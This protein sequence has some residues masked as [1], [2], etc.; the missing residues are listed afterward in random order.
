MKELELPWTKIKEVTTDGAASMIGKKIG[1]MG[2][3]RREIYKQNPEFYMNF[4][5]SATKSHVVDKH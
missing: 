4:T 3:I 5:A 1:L 2:S